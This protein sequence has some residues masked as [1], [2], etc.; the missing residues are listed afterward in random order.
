MARNCNHKS[1]LPSGVELCSLLRRLSASRDGRPKSGI[2]G[3]IRPEQISAALDVHLRHPA[4]GDHSPTYEGVISDVAS[5]AAERARAGYYPA[6]GSGSRS[7]IL[8]FR[9]FYPG[10]ALIKRRRHW[11]SQAFTRPCQPDPVRPLPMSGGIWWRSAPSARELS[12]FQTSSP[13][14]CAHGLHRRCVE[15]CCPR[16]RRGGLRATRVCSNQV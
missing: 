16:K 4:G 8:A 13:I 10:E 3:S 5:I 14:L 6:G 11:W 2:A 12:I 1:V 7:P 9:I 15:D